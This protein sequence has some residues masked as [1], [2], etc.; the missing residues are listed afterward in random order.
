M[1]VTLNPDTTAPESQEVIAR[2]DN[3][4]IQLEFSEAPGKQF[5]VEVSYQNTIVREG[6]IL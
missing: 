6:F 3:E 2:T 4:I 1:K 5:E